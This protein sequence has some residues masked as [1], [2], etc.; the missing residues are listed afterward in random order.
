MVEPPWRNWKA[1]RP[2]KAMVVGSSPTGGMRRVAATGILG[3]LL[4]TTVTFSPYGGANRTFDMSG[5][6]CSAPARVLTHL[7]ELDSAGDLDHAV[8]DGVGEDA[9][10]AALA[11]VEIPA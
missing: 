1:Q 9:R 10:A 6:L 4:A 2:F 11:D 7:V 8:A 5:G 3:A